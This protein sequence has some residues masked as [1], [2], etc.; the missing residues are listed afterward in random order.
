VRWFTHVPAC[1]TLACREGT[2]SASKGVHLTIDDLSAA[3]CFPPSPTRITEA[4]RAGLCPPDSAFDIFLPEDLEN[5]SGDQWTP[6]EVALSA[7][8]WLKELGVRRVVD[9]GSGPGKF[10]VATAL[11]TDCEFVG[12]EQNPR[13]VAVARS[14]ARLFGV[15][16]R[17]RFVQGILGDAVLPPADAYY[18]Y[19]PFAQHLFAPSNDLGWGASPDYQRYRRDVMTAQDVFRRAPTGTIVL[20]Y[21]GFGGLMPASYEACGIDRELPCVLRMWRKLDPFDDDG[22]STD[23]AD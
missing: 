23:D 16:S 3:V 10:C 2:R 20:T 22:F 5:L 8:R 4:L 21:N 15:Q 17:V 11:A 9:I 7:A 18:L 14:L 12:L 6:L 1:P 13:F 19:N